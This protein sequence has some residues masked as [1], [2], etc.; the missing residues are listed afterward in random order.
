MNSLLLQC[1]IAE[2]PVAGVSVHSIPS[3]PQGALGSVAEHSTQIV[4]I[5]DGEF[6]MEAYQLPAHLGMEIPLTATNCDNPVF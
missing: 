2:F 1:W 6:R 5:E 4:L 3:A